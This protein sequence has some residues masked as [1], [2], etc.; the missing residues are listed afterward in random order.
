MGS[1]EANDGNEI[2][3]QQMFREDHGEGG[4]KPFSPRANVLEKTLPFIPQRRMH[5][6]HGG[7]RGLL[8][9]ML[10]HPFFPMTFLIR[11]VVILERE[12]GWGRLSPRAQN[13]RILKLVKDRCLFFKEVLDWLSQRKE[14]SKLEPEK[15][16]VKGHNDSP[17]AYCTHCGGCCELRSGLPDF[18]PES[19]IPDRWKE[20]FGSGLGK[21]SRFCPFLWEFKRSGLS[22]CSIHPFRSYPCR[23]YEQEEC[24]FL[25][26]DPDYLENCNP[27]RFRRA[28]DRLFHLIDGA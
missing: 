13:A 3:I 6:L 24:E 7:T 14:C 12:P 22:F 16:L 5:R 1:R 27:L 4:D 25:Q 18:P 23:V 8:R 20:I 21:N 19:P 10:S 9:K 2:L 28:C 15:F 26:N 11:N 17:S